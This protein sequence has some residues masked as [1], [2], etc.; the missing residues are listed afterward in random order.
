M[1]LSGQ[2]QAGFEPRSVRFSN[3]CRFTIPNIPALWTNDCRVIIAT[4]SN[5]SISHKALT[6]VWISNFS[7]T[8]FP[9]IPGFVGAVVNFKHKWMW[10]NWTH[11]GFCSFISFPSITMVA[12][13][14]WRVPSAWWDS[15]NSPRLNPV[16][17]TLK[18]NSHLLQSADPVE[19]EC[20]HY[21]ISI[22]GICLHLKVIYWMILCLLPGIQSDYAC[23]FVDV[24]G[25]S[26]GDLVTCYH[27]HQSPK[28]PK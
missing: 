19:G 15:G 24:P 25:G 18:P 3:P 8:Y 26:W 5:P 11:S 16:C 27:L 22:S 6:V 21:Y 14:H 20:G 17:C 2:G 28:F 13:M 10:A 12:H 1:A 4:G 7:H 9:V 23:E